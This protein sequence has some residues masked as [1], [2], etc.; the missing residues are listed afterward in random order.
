M[1]AVTHVDGSCRVQSVSNDIN[2]NFY[3]LIRNFYELT[4]IPMLINTSFN[5]RGEPTVLSPVDA[6]RCFLNS[7][8]DI[9]V[10]NGN[11]IIY[12]NQLESVKK[13]RYEYTESLMVD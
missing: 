4:K 10:F 3:R 2:P 6:I 11:Y 9:L 1:P 5:L 13:E 8:I 7:G 12:K